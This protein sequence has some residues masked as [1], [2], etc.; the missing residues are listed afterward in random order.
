MPLL[1]IRLQP[2]SPAALA[3][4]SKPVV[5]PP[6]A[7]CKLPLPPA[8]LTGSRKCQTCGGS[9]VLRLTALRFRTCL[10]CAGQ[11]MLPVVP[12][13]SSFEPQPQLVPALDQLMA[14]ARAI[15]PRL[16]AEALFQDLPN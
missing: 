2:A 4:L 1:P 3:L 15:Q 8:A 10:D 7:S 6:E 5:A 16:P 14:S 13:R 11:G 9:G 12:A